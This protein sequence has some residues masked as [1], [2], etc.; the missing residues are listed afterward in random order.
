MCWPATHFG[1]API[2]SNLPSHS[3]FQSLRPSKRD[4]DHRK[5]PDPG[6]GHKSKEIGT[7]KELSRPRPGQKGSPAQAHQPIVSG[8]E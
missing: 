5:P 6:A 1:L 3:S 2:A 4:G 8:D 7:A